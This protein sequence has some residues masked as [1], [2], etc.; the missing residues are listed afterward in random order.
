MEEE[1]RKERKG[2]KGLHWLFSYQD[3]FAFE[4]STLS[5]F[6]NPPSLVFLPQYR[7]PMILM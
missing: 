5:C 4:L 3:L 1:G 2:R 6:F 7:S